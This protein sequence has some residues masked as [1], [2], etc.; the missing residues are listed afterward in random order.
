MKAV[1]LTY[2][3]CLMRYYE[4]YLLRISNQLRMLGQ[5]YK[6]ASGRYEHIMQG[7]KT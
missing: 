2:L 7:D 5:R 4:W 1:R 3:W 6:W